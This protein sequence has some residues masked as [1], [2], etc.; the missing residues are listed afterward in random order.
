MFT[1]IGPTLLILGLVASCAKEKSYDEL[2][3][4]SDLAHA[5]AQQEKLVFEQMCTTDDPC[6]WLPS[7]AETPF[8]VT[9]SR[10]YWQGAEKLVVTSLNNQG[11]LQFLHLEKDERFQNNINNLS[12][13]L[14]IDIEHVDY[15]CKEDSY[16]DCTNVEEVDSDKPWN[17][18][19]F[20]KIKDVNV[21]ETNTLPIELGELFRQGCFS[22]L[23]KNITK[24]NIEKDSMNLKVKKT[25]KAKASCIGLNSIEQLRY[26]TFTVDYT[27]SVV[28]LSSLADKN[29]EPVIYPGSDEAK[30]GFFKT[31]LHK[32]TVDNHDHYMGGRLSLANRW[33][34]N[35]KIV[36]YYLSE[37]FFTPEMKNIKRR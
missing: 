25:Y 24:L 31:E 33:S 10:P 22:E 15:K 1:K 11:K 18:R 12:P 23:D 16:G 7:V 4:T 6:L 36:P 29:Y 3:K 28:K 21:V 27:Y 5:Q 14:N 30:F 32:K 9:A 8:E 2:A 19:R 20:V 26:M 35:K 34:P 13:V 17:K 37:A